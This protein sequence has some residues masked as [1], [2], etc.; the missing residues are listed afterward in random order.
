M[1]KTLALILCFIMVAAIAVSSIAADDYKAIDSRELQDYGQYHFYL[2]DPATGTAIPTVDGKVNANEY[3]GVLEFENDP[4]NALVYVS[5]GDNNHEFMDNEWFKIYISYDEETLYFGY[6]TKDP[7]FVT[8][9]DRICHMISFLD[10]G[11]HVS[12]VGRFNFICKANADG[13]VT[14]EMVNFRKAPDGGW[15]KDEK[16]NLDTFY[17]DGS[18]SYDEATQ[19]LT[20]EMAAD[21]AA[22]MEW[23]GNDLDLSDARLYYSAYVGCYGESVKGAGDSVFQG[24]VWSY[25][26]ATKDIPN[27]KMNFVLDYPDI[28][29]WG[30]PMF[31]PH[32]VHFCEE[33][34]P[35]TAAPTE[36]TTTATTTTKAATTAKATTA[37]ATTAVATTAAAAEATTAAA[38]TAAAEKGCGGTIAL[39][40]LALVPMLGAAVVIG[41]KKE[42]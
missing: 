9:K 31:F 21:I 37:K 2:G 4:S 39:T 5:G 41:K 34:E 42:N 26:D 27:L 38:T 40:A 20:I 1:K 29:Y 3:Q 32:I 15:N 19:V 33:P 30:N 18:C 16:L 35:T 11:S 6:E 28:S 10:D 25:L 22:C 17:K 36:A 12:A 7:N 24:Y 8:A 23:W 14:A 13:T